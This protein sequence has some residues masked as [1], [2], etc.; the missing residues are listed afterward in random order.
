[1]ANSGHAEPPPAALNEAFSKL[2]QG[3]T[4]TFT[5]EP[6]LPRTPE[7]ERERVAAALVFVAQVI[8]AEIDRDI[9]NDY[10][11]EL[12][13]AIADLNRGIVRPLLKPSPRHGRVGDPSD[14]WRA[15]ARI[16]V[17]LE[18]LMRSRL[19]QTE[20]AGKIAREYPDLA[21]LAGKKAG[22]FPTTIIGWHAEFSKKR[23]KNFEA[24][25]LFAVG[26]E[27]V[28]ELSD[29]P[30]GLKALAADQLEKSRKGA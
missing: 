16:S 12:S 28:D 23:V 24:E 22:K 13:S 2:R 30:D 15:R 25:G 4:T 10:F 11:F 19:T 17:A 26:I 5:Q 1:M 6:T 7:N 20:A 9:A 8:A 29:D 21:A 14:K 3:L 18:A 27:H